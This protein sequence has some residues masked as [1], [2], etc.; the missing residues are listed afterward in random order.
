MFKLGNLC[1][2]VKSKS[3]V[4]FTGVLLVYCVLG[5]SNQ[6]RAGLTYDPAGTTTVTATSAAEG[7]TMSV[8]FSNNAPDLLTSYSNIGMY[9]PSDIFLFAYHKLRYSHRN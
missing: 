4:F 5:A 8:T 3:R 2:G 7:I 9:Q 6:A 1:V